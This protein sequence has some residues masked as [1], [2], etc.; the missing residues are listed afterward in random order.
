MIHENFI[1]RQK[2]CVCNC[3]EQKKFKLTETKNS[4]A[5]VDGAC[6]TLSTG[7]IVITKVFFKEE[8]DRTNQKVLTSSPKK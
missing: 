7:D 4:R 6:Q 1:Y 2:I 8:Q 5:M 3:S